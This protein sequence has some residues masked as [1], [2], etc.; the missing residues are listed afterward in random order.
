MDGEVLF[1]KGRDDENEWDD[2]ELIKWW[3]ESEA[4]FKKALQNKDGKGK[5]KWKVGDPCRCVWEE[6]GQEYE[7]EIVEIKQNEG[8]CVVNY[9]GYD[10]EAEVNLTDLMESHGSVMQFRQVQQIDI[11]NL[12][13]EVDAVSLGSD[14][15]DESDTSSQ[16]NTDVSSVKSKTRKDKRKKSRRQSRDET[17]SIGS[18]E[19]SSR[20]VP[21]KGFP[22]VPTMPGFPPMPPQQSFNPMGPPFGNMNYNFQ[23][24]PMPPFPGFNMFGMGN[25]NFQQLPPMPPPPMPQSCDVLSDDSEALHSMLMAWYMSGYHAGLYEGLRKRKMKKNKK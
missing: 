13:E 4:M 11:D 8:K 22:S 15:Q 5:K 6:D 16:M 2:T 25:M 12:P 7:A 17:Y 18:T 19:S 14:D 24:P 3:D 21:F 9:C 1:M 20:N 10:E 23:M